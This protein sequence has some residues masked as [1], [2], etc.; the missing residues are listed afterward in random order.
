MHCRRLAG[1]HQP[2]NGT[3]AQQEGGIDSNNDACRDN[4]VQVLAE[5]SEDK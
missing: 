2:G 4:E 5:D 3:N 1:K